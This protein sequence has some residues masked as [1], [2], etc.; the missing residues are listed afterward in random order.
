MSFE[1]KQL[2]VDRSSSI[3]FCEYFHLFMKISLTFISSNLIVF[4]YFNY[5]H[6]Q[7][8]LWGTTFH[9]HFHSTQTI[10]FAVLCETVIFLATY[11]ITPLTIVLSLLLSNALFWAGV[12]YFLALICPLKRCISP[13][14]ETL[15]QSPSKSST[16]CCLSLEVPVQGLAWSRDYRWFA[17]I[18]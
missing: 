3:L 14:A 6:A 10:G 13:S 2:L 11:I 18:E 12:T 4:I 5:A 8:M 1:M 7:F 16:S 9:C 17:I 15:S